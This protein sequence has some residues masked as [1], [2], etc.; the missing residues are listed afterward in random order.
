MTLTFQLLTLTFQLL[1]RLQECPIQRLTPP[2]WTF[3]ITVLI[4]YPI[5]M[6]LLNPLPPILLMT[7][8]AQTLILISQ[9]LKIIFSHNL[10]LLM[11]QFI[12]KSPEHHLVGPTGFA[13]R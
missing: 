12:M 9:N 11:K 7:N 6:S 13:I 2:H 8:T 4:L 1:T 10:K 3:K 5:I